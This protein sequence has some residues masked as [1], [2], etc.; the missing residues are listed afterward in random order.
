MA[1]GSTER[2]VARH[3]GCLEHFRERGFTGGFF[4]Q[5]DARYPRHCLSLDYTPETLEEVIDHFAQ[6]CGSDYRTAR[7][8]VDG[9]VVRSMEGT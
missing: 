3:A 6:W 2:P 7:V 8:T 1:R 4:Q 5:H 9:E